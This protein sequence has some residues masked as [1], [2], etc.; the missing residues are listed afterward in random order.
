MELLPLQFQ[1]S[2]IETRAFNSLIFLLIK[3]AVYSLLDS[4]P[5]CKFPL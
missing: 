4:Y 2:G 5:I 3:I 1:I